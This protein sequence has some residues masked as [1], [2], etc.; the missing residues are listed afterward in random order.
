M[1]VLCTQRHFRLLGLGKTG[2]GPPIELVSSLGIEDHHPL[3]FVLSSTG[4][5]ISILLEKYTVH[6][7]KFSV[8]R[9]WG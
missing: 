9:F 2:A 6:I 1:Q 5:H 7:N 3:N 4:F 8:L